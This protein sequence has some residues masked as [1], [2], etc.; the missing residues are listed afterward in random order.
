MDDA[1]P[2]TARILNLERHPEG[3]WYRRMFTSSTVF[4]VAGRGHERPIGTSILFYL[5]PGEQSAWHSIVPDELWLWH[6]GS[7]LE[8]FINAESPSE[9]TVPVVLG[10]D[11]RAGQ[12]PQFLVP[13][14]SWQSARPVD[15]GDALV[16]C[17]LFPGFHFDDF[18]LAPAADP[19]HE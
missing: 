19:D 1:I 3:G 13:G 18:T 15:G 9:D 14:G 7:P 8:L 16:S 17:A 10:P 12:H 11:I 5:A 4:E 2:E 6:S